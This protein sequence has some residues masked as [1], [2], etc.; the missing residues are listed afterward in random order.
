MRRLVLLLVL[1]AVALEGCAPGPELLQ[2]AAVGAAES[3]ETDRAV[4]WTE[5]AERQGAAP[6]PTLRTR[7]L[8]RAG[9][10]EE[11]VAAYLAAPAGPGRDGVLSGI[12]VAAIQDALV[13]G[14]RAVLEAGALPPGNGGPPWETPLLRLALLSPDPAVRAAAARGLGARKDPG[15]RA[16]LLPLA[17][18]RHAFVRAAAVEALVPTEPLVIAAV[19]QT[20][21]DRDW[22]VRV[23]AASALARS[24][25]SAGLPVLREA[26]AQRD[27]SV[28]MAAALG[29]VP[30]RER[31]VGA[32][33]EARLADHDPY[34]R[35]SVAEA[36]V[37][38]G[39]A[40]GREALHRTLEAPDRSLALYAAEILAGL[41]DETPRPLLA[42]V[43]ADQAAPAGVRLYAAWILGRLGDGAGAPVVAGYLSAVE[44]P[45]R[46]RTAWTLG[47]IGAEAARPALR[48]ALADRDPGVRAHAALALAKLAGEA[49]PTQ[50]PP[51]PLL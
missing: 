2:A 17:G 32:L 40:V 10:L 6:L 16:L 14:Q 33:L 43:L 30:V 42:A 27:P 23:A 7:L 22:R 35:V 25:N 8:L 38:R 46:L 45:L 19:R 34:V 24:G 11:A 12:Y 29:L 21:R 36:L 41:G 47:E 13:R 39:E 49:Q 51:R 31:S 26:L 1:L 44:A 20:L 3:G 50:V 18:D 9:R 28:R 48:L 15:A 37:Q 4:A 5:R